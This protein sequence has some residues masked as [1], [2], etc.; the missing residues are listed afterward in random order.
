VQVMEVLFDGER[1][2][3]VKI[4]EENGTI[5]EVRAKV[6]VDASGQSGLLQQKFKLRVWD[7]TLN[8]GAIWTYWE[9]AYRDTGRDE[10]A[11]MVIQT[12]NRQ[13]WFW[14]IPLHND[15]ISVGVVAEGTK[16]SSGSIVIQDSPEPGAWRIKIAGTGYFAAVAKGNGGIAFPPLKLEQPKPG[17][18]Q[19][20]AAYLA[21]P[22]DSAE[23]QIISPGGATLQVIPMTRVDT[24]FRGVFTPPAEP[25]HIAGEGKDKQ[26]LL[27]RRIHAPLLETLK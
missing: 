22:V 8:R 21:G 3:G 24:E 5:R 14:Y 25:F 1:A 6:V 15:I 4:R 17:V 2:V 13:G 7:P 23:F 10:G 18:E 16:L 27:F 11:T 26:G 9:G 20:L 19:S 12:T